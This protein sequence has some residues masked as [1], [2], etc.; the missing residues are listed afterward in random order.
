VE[1]ANFAIRYF[2]AAKNFYHNTLYHQLEF[3]N[4][5]GAGLEKLPLFMQRL[6]AGHADQFINNIRPVAFMAGLLEKP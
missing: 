6:P 4:M 1:A 5:Y 3:A 2:E